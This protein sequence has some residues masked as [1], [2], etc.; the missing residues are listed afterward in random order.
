MANEFAQAV[1]GDP[2]KAA[3]NII[4]LVTRPELPLRFVVGDDSYAHFKAFYEKRLEELEA[5]RELSTG[6]NFN[7]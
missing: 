6:T 3:R 2:V 4:K 1:P 5:A 7:E